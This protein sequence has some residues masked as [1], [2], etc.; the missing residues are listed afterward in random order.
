VY[1]AE[2]GVP[3]AVLATAVSGGELSARWALFSSE[4]GG[5][6]ELAGKRLAVAATGAKDVQFVDNAM[7]DSELPKHFGARQSAPDIASAVAAVSL[8]K[9][10]CVFAPESLGKSG[11]RRVY[12]AG[13]VPNPALVDVKGAA[14]EVLAKVKQA[15]AGASGVSPYD[16]WRAA[17]S[18]A[19]RALAGRLGP[20][21]RRPVM[22]EPETVRLDDGE[23]LVR[24]AM[25]TATA[26]VKDQYWLPS[27]TP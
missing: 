27:G 19:Y 21:A 9:A 3:W 26:D 1:L 6:G 2:R 18:D 25:P 7:L 12:E 24:A 5:I 17:S 10:N 15:A 16:G 14:G 23:V 11:L 8:H 4:S 13:R 22:S 20:K